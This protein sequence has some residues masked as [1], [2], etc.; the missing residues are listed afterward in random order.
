M[1]LIDHEKLMSYPIGFVLL[2]V[3]ECSV[4]QVVV[5]SGGAR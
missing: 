3:D 2:L 1:Q 4:V 5:A